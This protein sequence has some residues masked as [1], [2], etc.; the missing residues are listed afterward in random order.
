MDL[1]DLNGKTA[2]VTG[3]NRGIGLMMSRG[4]LQAGA[5][6]IIS[7]RKADAC[8]AAVAELSSY[9]SVEAITADL[10]SVSATQE[11]AQ[12]V[13]ERVGTLD[14]L[15]NNAGATWG[16]GFDDFPETAWDKVMD[17]NA[18]APFYL[19][20]ACLPLLEASGSAHDPARVVNIGSIDGMRVPQFDSFSYSASK[21]A[22]HQITRMLAK[23]LGPRHIT[24][25]AIAPGPFPSKMMTAIIDEFEDELVASS[26]L[27][28]IGRADDMAGAVVYLTSRAGSWLTGVVLPVD[29]GIFTTGS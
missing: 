17:V 1:F 19:T 7:G 14:I 25:N 18:K 26:P 23:H 15:V 13:S 10:S 24:V 3:G 2:L 27:G 5:S 4:L 9:G 20:Q 6:V 29:G 22:I 11:L 21:A 28:R 8:E 16:A 12:A